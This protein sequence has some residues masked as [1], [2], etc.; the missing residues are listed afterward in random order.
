MRRR[1]EALEDSNTAKAKLGKQAV[2]QDWSGGGAPLVADFC[3]QYVQIDHTKLNGFGVDD[4]LWMVLGRP[5]LSLAVDVKSKAIVSHVLSFVDPSVSTLGQ[6]LYRMALPKRVPS[7]FAERYPILTDLRGKPTEVIVDNAVEFRSLAME[8]AA[9]GAGFNIRWCPVKKPRYRAVVE[10]A[11]GTIN[12]MICEFLPGRTLPPKDARRLGHNPEMGACVLVHEIEAIINYCISLYN[13]SP[14]ED[15]G[16][17]PAMI[18]QNDANRYG[19]NNFTD[20]DAFRIDTFNI[21]PQAQLSSSGIRAFNGLRYFHNQNVRALLDDLKAIEPRRQRRDAA[22]ATV[23]FRYDPADISCIYVWNRR[24]RKWVKLFCD[25]ERY[26]DGMPLAFHNQIQ[27]DA[28]RRGAEFNTPTERKLAKA[29]LIAAIKSI[30]PEASARARKQVAELYEIPRL[31]Q[32]TGNIVHLHSAVP[33]A[34][35]LSDFLGNDRAELT[36]LDAEILAPRPAPT[37]RR[38]NRNL[39][40]RR[41]ARAGLTSP[42]AQASQQEN[43]PTDQSQARPRRRVQGKFDHS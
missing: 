35:T 23:D 4:D 5:W 32:I 24:S 13:T 33:H 28:K 26:A 2:E 31:R 8:A 3:M 19:I 38:S 27:D 29:K 17:Q 43:P 7:A 37:P 25:D 9:R 40:E 6:I 21:Q 30:S 14:R 34:V 22:T 39:A 20:I 42:N 18:F 12:R 15:C 16:N 11:I 36:A 41:E 10:R 1:I